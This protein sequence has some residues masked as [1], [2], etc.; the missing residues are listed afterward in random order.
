[1][2]LMYKT[3]CEISGKSIYIC[4]ISAASDTVSILFYLINTIMLQGM[5]SLPRTDEETSTG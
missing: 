2:F 5:I 1:M 3:E 4:C